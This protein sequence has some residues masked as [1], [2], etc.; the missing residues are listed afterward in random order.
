M[1][2]RSLDACM[3]IRKPKPFTV[4]SHLKRPKIVCNRSNHSLSGAAEQL[5]K[6]CARPR[7][8]LKYF[9]RKQS[10]CLSVC[11]SVSYIVIGYSFFLLRAQETAQPTSKHKVPYIDNKPISTKFSLLFQS[12]CKLDGFD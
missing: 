2:F 6:Y 5:N 3:H 12:S 1:K 4:Y 9:P 8:L 11:L 7:R 10:L